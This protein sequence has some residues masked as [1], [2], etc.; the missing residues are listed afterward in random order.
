MGLEQRT[1]ECS[2]SLLHPFV[3]GANDREQLDQV[4]TYRLAL[5][6][7]GCPNHVDQTHEG[8]LDVAAK[9]VKI[10]HQHLCRDIGWSLRSSNAS[11]LL[12]DSCGALHELD[13][14][15]PDCGVVVSRVL[16]QRLGAVS[17]TH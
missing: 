8:V 4:L 6:P 14:G 11:S 16:C 10:G 3:M 15:Q 17:Y 1:H 9:D 2:T 7:A 13:V 12:V 5:I